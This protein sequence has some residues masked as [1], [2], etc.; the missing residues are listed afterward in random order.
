MDAVLRHRLAG[1]LA[2]TAAALTVPVAALHA[3]LDEGFSPVS[4]GWHVLIMVTGAGVALAAAL[5]LIAFGASTRDGRAVCVGGAFAVMASLLGAHGLATPMVFTGPN[6]VVALTGAAALP[7]G[8]ALLMLATLPS[9]QR[10][11]HLRMLVRLQV[12]LVAVIL[13]ALG[14]ALVRP[15]A[16]PGVPESASPAAVALLVVGAAIFGVLTWRAAGTFALTRRGADL[17]V[18]V[19]AAWLGFAL[20]PVLLV[21]QGTWAWWLGHTFEFVGVALV[22]L[23]VALDLWRAAPSRTLTGDLPAAELVRREESFLGPRIQGLLADLARKDNSTEEHTRRVALLAV[24]VGE[25]LGLAP[26]RLR[27]LAVGGLLHDMGKL[28]VPNAILCKPG[29]LTDE[30]MAVIRCHPRWGDELLAGL[31][32]PAR[33]RRMVAGHH[34][35][36]DGGGYPDGVGDVELDLETRILTVCDVYDALV[37]PR[38]Y[39]G[40]WEPERALALLHEET[41]T[42]FDRRCV[43]ALERVLAAMPVPAAARA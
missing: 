13:A 19:G 15:S 1:W 21:E 35:R 28:A 26:G 3:L 36:L 23:P 42:A 37:S 16:V 22:G 10:P 7:V 40:A 39:R 8:G 6:G 34:E 29:R 24:Q 12:L 33:V 31:G 27:E 5:G 2:L 38:V 14:V 41:G 43:L 30:E 11:R 18:L 4:G 9:L 17:A 20:V 32:F 25:A